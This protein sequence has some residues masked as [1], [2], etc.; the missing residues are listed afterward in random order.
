MTVESVRR[1]LHKQAAESQ[2]DTVAMYERWAAEERRDGNAALAAHYEQ[3][4]AAERRR[5]LPNVA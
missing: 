1:E 2:D 4:A 3:K 5:P